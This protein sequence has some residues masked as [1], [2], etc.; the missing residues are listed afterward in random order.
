MLEFATVRGAQNAALSH[1]IGTLTPGKEVDIVIVRAGDVNTMPLTNAVATVVCYAHAGNVDTVFIAGV[2]RKWA[3]KLVDVDLIGF[4]ERVQLAGWIVP[5]PGNKGG[6]PRMIVSG[7]IALE[8]HCHAGGPR[9]QL[10]QELCRRPSV[11]RMTPP[12]NTR[13]PRRWRSGG[14]EQPGWF[15]FQSNTEAR[16]LE[17]MQTPVRH[18]F[19]SR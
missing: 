8:R 14:A 5:T 16:E 15:A 2:A 9:H 6:C 13:S 12:G 11:L 10:M 19:G 3:G 18:F 1:K 4:R 17:R 7:E